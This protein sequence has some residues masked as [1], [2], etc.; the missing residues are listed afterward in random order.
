MTNKINTD[1]RLSLKFKPTEVEAE[2]IDL[3]VDDY[4]DYKTGW[5]VQE[6]KGSVYHLKDFYDIEE[7]WF[8]GEG[9][10][11]RMIER[12]EDKFYYAEKY[13]HA[14]GEIKYI[15]II[16]LDD[17][18]ILENLENDG[19]ESLEHGYYIIYKGDAYKETFDELLK[20]KE[21]AEFLEDIALDRLADEKVKVII[22]CEKESILDFL[23]EQESFEDIY[24]I[25][26]N[27]IKYYKRKYNLTED[28]E[29]DDSEE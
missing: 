25:F 18:D 27:D 2:I 3:L 6:N 17:E 19:F 26:T 14:A 24:D 20:N 4:Q 22:D 13:T 29:D 23:N 5:I 15:N 7:C 11:G 8:S 1:P 16:D 21:I 28:D 12:Y 10:T 9:I